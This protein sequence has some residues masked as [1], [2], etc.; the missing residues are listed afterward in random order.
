[1]YLL[2]PVLHPLGEVVHPALHVCRKTLVYL[3]GVCEVEALHDPSELLEALGQ[4]GVVGLL[5][6]HGGAHHPLVVVGGEQGEVVGQGEDLVP[7][8]PVQ[9][10]GAPAL[11]ISSAT[12]T[13]EERV[14]S[15]GAAILSGSNEYLHFIMTKQREKKPNR[16]VTRL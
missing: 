14:T 15:E 16:F 5:L 6:R 2:H 12:A 9:D 11:E 10:G 13:N 4:P 8:A 1:M 7:H 3:L